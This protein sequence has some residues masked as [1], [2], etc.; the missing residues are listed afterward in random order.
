MA[1]QIKL[2]AV[3]VVGLIVTVGGYLG[4]APDEEPEIDPNAPVSRVLPTKGLYYLWTE[5]IPPEP[6]YAMG[7]RL[8][9]QDAADGLEKPNVDAEV[10]LNG[11]GVEIHWEGT[12]G[13]G[14]GI[15]HYDVQVMYEDDDWVDW[16]MMTTDTDAMYYPTEEGD[17][18]FRCRATDNVGNVEDWPDTPDTQFKVKVIKPGDIIERPDLPD[19]PWWW[20]CPPG[21]MCINEK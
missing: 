19:D 10:L 16:R 15:A 21:M 18:Y 1:I 14:T 11:D 8:P 3:I 12:D 20:Y 7:L 9:V 5:P 6:P 2:V 17:Y 4:A 13:A